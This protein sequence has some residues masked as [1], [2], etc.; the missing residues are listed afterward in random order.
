MPPLR[1]K[2]NGREEWGH[3]VLGPWDPTELSFEPAADD[4]QKQEVCPMKSSLV[5]RESDL[6]LACISPSSL[7]EVFGVE[8]PCLQ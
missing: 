2:R 8:H 5:P 4:G 3:S 1:H 7:F 6:C